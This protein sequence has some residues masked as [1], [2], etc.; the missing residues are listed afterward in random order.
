[1][2]Q[3]V[4]L[5]LVGGI[6]GDMF[7][8]AMLDA[9]PA[10]ATE[11]E[12]LVSAAGFPDLVRLEHAPHH[13]GVLTGT[14]FRVIAGQKAHHHRQYGDILDII[15]RS[16]I[17]PATSEVALAMFNDIA[18]AEADIHGT[19]VASVAFHEIGAWD[20]IADIIL[21]AHVIVAVAARSWSVSSV[22]LGRGLIDTA[23]GK[24][25]VPAPATCRLLE[26]FEVHD[27]GVAGERV[28]PTGAAILKYL[29]AATPVPVT[30]APIAGSPMTGVPAG[31]IMG[32]SGY[33]FGTRQFPGCS[34][35][36]RAVVYRYPDR[37]ETAPDHPARPWVEDQVIRL[38][39]ELDDQTPESIA[40][41]LEKIR[42]L[43]GVLDV[44]QT[45]CWGKKNRQGHAIAILVA[46]DRGTETGRMR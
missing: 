2:S 30:D 19:D 10:L 8:G 29:A 32:Q 14:R 31:L 17:S 35:V 34:N 24:L 23:H 21:A 26:G 1:M 36:L 27:D 7:I 18:R 3:H 25:P 33:G 44:V 11:L 43:D 28:T 42:Q 4:H 20:S 40:P 12:D 38:S 9:F 39:F 6:S 13:D 16:N 15:S 22:P 46:S 45:P 41:G 37:A 5:D